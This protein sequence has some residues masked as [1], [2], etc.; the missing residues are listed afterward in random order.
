MT[1]VF[2]ST[3]WKKNTISNRFKVQALFQY[4]TLIKYTIHI[5]NK[6]D[7]RQ[8][9]YWGDG[10]R[11]NRPEMAIPYM[12]LSY[13][14]NKSNKHKTNQTPPRKQNK[15]KNM[16]KNYQ[17]ESS[18]IFSYKYISN[19]MFDHAIRS[20]FTIVYFCGPLKSCF[21]ICEHNTVL[22]F[23]LPPPPHTHPICK[24]GMIIINVYSAHVLSKDRK[25]NWPFIRQ[26]DCK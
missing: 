22:L 18:V 9:W 5:K 6:N 26:W 15:N 1:K 25:N 10:E 4:Q 14:Y 16:P 8:T 2:L 11:P 3:K 20:Y 13:T 17:N 19:P 24:I 21:H 12:N 7:T 23:C